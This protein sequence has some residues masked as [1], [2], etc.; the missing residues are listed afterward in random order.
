MTNQDCPRPYKTLEEWNNEPSFAMTSRFAGLECLTHKEGIITASTNEVLIKFKLERALYRS[1][2]VLEDPG[3]KRLTGAVQHWWNGGV[4]S[5]KVTLPKAG[6][7]S[8]RFLGRFTR[9]DMDNKERKDDWFPADAS[10]ALENLLVSYTIK[11]TGSQQ[12]KL[13]SLYKNNI[14]FGAPLDLPDAGL[15]PATENQGIIKAR[16]GAAHIVYQRIGQ[17]PSKV[18]TKLVSFKDDQKELGSSIYCEQFDSWI[19]CHIRCPSAGQFALSLFVNG[20]NGV[21]CFVQ[22]IIVSESNVKPKEIPVIHGLAGPRDHFEE[23]GVRLKDPLSSTIVTENGDGQLA[24]TWDTSK[25]LQLICDLKDASGSKSLQEDGHVI[26]ETDKEGLES[27]TTIYIRLK[28]K[29]LYKLALFGKDDSMPNNLFLGHWLVVCKKPSDKNLYPERASVMGPRKAFHSLGLETKTGSRIMC[30]NGEAVMVVSSQLESKVEFSYSLSR[31]SDDIKKGQV[32]ADT[33][34]S[35][36]Q[37]LTTF[38]FRTKKIGSY[39][40]RL[41]ARPNGAESGTYV[42]AWHIVSDA[43]SKKPEFPGKHD[44][45]GPNKSFRSAGLQVDETKSKMLTLTAGEA[46]LCLTH[47]PKSKCAITARLETGK[48]QYPQTKV[49]VLIEKEWSDKDRVVT[50]RLRLRISDPGLYDLLVFTQKDENAPYDYSGVWLVDCAAPSS[51]PLF[52]SS[53]GSMGPDENFFKMGLS[54]VSPRC[55]TI[56]ASKDGICTLSV[57]RDKPFATLFKD[58]QQECEIKKEETSDGKQVT[59]TMRLPRAG[60]FGLKM[61][62]SEPGVNT[63]DFMGNWLLE[64][65]Q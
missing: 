46:E 53:H 12:T 33:M 56:K 2:C 26:S 14:T 17:G 13:P 4:A 22:Y 36:K 32:F 18:N 27:T 37:R 52:P 20:A 51:K 61:Y 10:D 7:Y 6:K 25:K 41:F 48:G 1:F 44:A 19:A 29:G 54:L 49:S 21:S 11:A 28:E 35:H 16:N 40:F 5:C 9:R 45:Y 34:T 8:F 55:S 62:A 65:E 47:K 59:C 30:T 58:S 38:N 50:T 3:G 60:L 63:K 23:L 57:Q 64:W 39:A 15:V 42:G 43:A 31:T 24:V